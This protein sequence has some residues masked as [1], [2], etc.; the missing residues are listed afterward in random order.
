VTGTEVGT[1]APEGEPRATLEAVPIPRAVEDRDVR[2]DGNDAAPGLET[3]ILAGTEIRALEAGADVKVQEDLVRG[4]GAG[5][6]D[7]AVGVWSHEL[8]VLGVPTCAHL[9]CGMG[10]LEIR[11]E[12]HRLGGGEG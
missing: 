3:G 8:G 7:R 2:V 9:S 11:G 4:H 5:E 12:D 6:R 10:E 1:D